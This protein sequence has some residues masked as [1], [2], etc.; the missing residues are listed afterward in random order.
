MRKWPQR[1][2]VVVRVMPCLPGL[3]T[4]RLATRILP[5]PHLPDRTLI[6]LLAPPTPLFLPLHYSTT[7]TVV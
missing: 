1:D 4:A 3:L 7:S 5:L 6:G 2:E